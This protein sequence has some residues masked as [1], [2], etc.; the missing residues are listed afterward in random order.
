MTIVLPHRRPTA[1]LPSHLNHYA[2]LLLYSQAAKLHY[3]HGT[4]Q[5]LPRHM[6]HKYLWA[7]WQI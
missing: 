6:M 2:G 7:R 3:R 4:E 1:L 5:L